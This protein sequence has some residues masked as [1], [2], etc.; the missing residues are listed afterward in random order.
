[1]KIPLWPFLYNVLFYILEIS[2]IRVASMATY[3]FFLISYMAWLHSEIM[4]PSHPNTSLQSS[5]LSARYIH[6]PTRP[7]HLIS[8][9]RSSQG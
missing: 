2:S 7:P 8:N 9:L 5:F 4:G 6:M 3:I 1:M